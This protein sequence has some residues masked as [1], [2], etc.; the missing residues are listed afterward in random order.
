[1]RDPATYA[2]P[3]EFNPDRFLGKNPEPDPRG[4]IFGYGRRICEYRHF[5]IPLQNE[6]NNW[7]GPPFR[8]FFIG[9]AL[10]IAQTSLWIAYAMSLAVFNVEKYVD[11]S[12]NVVEPETRY[13]NGGIR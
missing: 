8:R 4:M 5:V 11:G 7:A 9:P 6:I 3:M 12:G 13:T 2:N 1:M 10:N